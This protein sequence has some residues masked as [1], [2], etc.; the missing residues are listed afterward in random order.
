MGYMTNIRDT[1]L[2]EKF[3]ARLKQ[4]RTAKGWTLEALAN[5]CDL[6]LSQIHRIEQGKINPTL[7]TIQAIAKGFNLSIAELLFGF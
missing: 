3:G 5:E 2:L 7:S 6:E 1:A 4:L